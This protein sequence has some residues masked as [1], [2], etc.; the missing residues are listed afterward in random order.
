[1]KPKRADTHVCQRRLLFAL[2]SA[3]GRLA[4]PTSG[5]GPHGSRSSPP[6][7]KAAYGVGLKGRVED[8]GSG[9]DDVRRRHP[10]GVGTIVL[11]PD[12]GGRSRH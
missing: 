6:S 8:E 10:A 7:T 11:V 5:P 1:V 9:L 3:G 12:P 2:T 4:D